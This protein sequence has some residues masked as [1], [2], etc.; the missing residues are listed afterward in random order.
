MNQNQA[1][2]NQ[3]TRLTAPFPYFGGKRLA[4]NLVWSRLGVVRNY[5]EPFAGSLSI[6]L[7]RPHPPWIETVNDIDAFLA[8]FWRAVKYAPEAVASHADWP[9]NEVDLLARYE[10]LVTTGLERVERVERMKDDPYYYDA[11]VAGWWVWGISQWLGSG[12]CEKSRRPNMKLPKLA[13][14]GNGIH[15]AGIKDLYAYMRS[16]SRRLRRVRVACGD[17]SRVMSRAVTYRNG[18][19]GVFLDPPYSAETDR[20]PKLYRVED[21]SVAHQVREWA[22]INGHN[23]LMRI[24]LCGYEGEHDMPADWECVSWRANRGYAKNKNRLR[25]RIWFSPHCLKPGD[26]DAA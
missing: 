3:K 22:I 19:T 21:L 14:Y 10:W 24:A 16:L 2:R 11:Q 1:P 15:R 23:P 4:A 17:W 6:L 13:S 26:P 12:W 25:E 9:V 8:N 20:N 5:I 18:L 7:A